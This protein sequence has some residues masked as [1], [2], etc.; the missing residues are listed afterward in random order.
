[1][2]AGELLERVDVAGPQ[3]RDPDLGDDLV[4][5]ERGGEMEID[6]SLAGIDRLP[7]MLT[8][9]TSPSR[10]VSRAGSSAAASA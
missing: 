6:S 4:L 9:V 10:A 7:R 1:M 3:R 8:A 2:T 5:R